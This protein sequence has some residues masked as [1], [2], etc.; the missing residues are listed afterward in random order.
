MNNNS[1]EDERRRAC[2]IYE[3]MEGTITWVSEGPINVEENRK[4]KAK[5]QKVRIRR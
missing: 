1:L 4:T 2:K 3:Q 5:R